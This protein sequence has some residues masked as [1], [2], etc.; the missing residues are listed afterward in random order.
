VVD[1]RWKVHRMVCWTCGKRLLVPLPEGTNLGKSFAQWQRVIG[2][3]ERYEKP[4]GCG[5]PYY[6]WATRTVGRKLAKRGVRAT[7][8]MRI[9]KE[10]VLA[11]LLS[12]T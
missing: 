4:C 9:P 3:L 5:S 11:L 12:K 6:L 7:R 10:R 8:P 1:L 2:L